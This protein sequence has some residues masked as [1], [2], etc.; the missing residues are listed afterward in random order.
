MF[1]ENWIIKNLLIPD[2]I[3]KLQNLVL[4]SAKVKNL[5]DLYIF[6][7]NSFNITLH[8]FYDRLVQDELIT[9]VEK[10]VIKRIYEKYKIPISPFPVKAIRVVTSNVKSQAPWHQDEGTWRHHE[11]LSNKNP[12]TCWLPIIANLDNTLQVCYD[13]IKVKDHKRD[14]LKRSYQEFSSEE[15]SNNIIIDPEIGSGYIFSCYQPH[16]TKIN[17]KKKTLRI[18]LDLRFTINH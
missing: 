6:I 2:E 13:E 15:L 5:E 9:L 18:S 16:R 8:K 7:N 3:V 12:Y 4:K 1:K 17:L 14:K 10:N 11:Y